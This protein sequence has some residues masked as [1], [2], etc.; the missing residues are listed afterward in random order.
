MRNLR[1]KHLA[2][3]MK[4]SLRKRNLNAR[5]VTQNLSLKT[6]FKCISPSSNI[7]YECNNNR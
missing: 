7:M 1:R 2:K 4:N 5:N 3:K 6:A